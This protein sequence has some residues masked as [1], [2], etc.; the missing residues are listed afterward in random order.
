MGLAYM[1]GICGWNLSPI[2]K[3]QCI[4]A[5][6]IYVYPSGHRFASHFTVFHLIFIS[7]WNLSDETHIFNFSF[8]V[9]TQKCVQICKIGSQIS[10]YQTVR[11][12]FQHPLHNS[13]WGTFF[14]DSPGTRNKERNFLVKPSSLG[15]TFFG[16]LDPEIPRFVDSQLGFSRLEEW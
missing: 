1:T 10:K 3:Y 13:N 15:K 9:Q 12:F 2:N 11:F 14:S 7:F 5:Y 8:L 4:C 6:V 16:I